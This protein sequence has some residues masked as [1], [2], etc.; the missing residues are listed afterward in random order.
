MIS[1]LLS[2]RSRPLARWLTFFSLQ[3]ASRA[4]IRNAFL[5]K[6]LKEKNKLCVP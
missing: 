6:T 2:N 4:L 5:L 3:A 1:S